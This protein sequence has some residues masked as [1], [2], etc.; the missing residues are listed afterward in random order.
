MLRTPIFITNFKTYE[1]AIG[2]NALKLAKIHQQVAED[3]GASIGI[4]VAACDL[5]RVSQAVSIPV[6][7]QHTDPVDYGSFT[8]HVLPQNIKKSGAVGTLLNHSERRLE[9]DVII[10]TLAC[11]QKA[12]LIRVLCAESPEELELLAQY[13]P[14]FLAFE[15]PELIGNSKKSVASEKP[16]SITHCVNISS[17][18]PV[19]VGAGISCADDIEVSLSLGA[20]GFL[21]ASAIVKSNDP[22]KALRKLVAAF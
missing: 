13:D 1:Q 8:G 9:K 16:T 11:S 21:V 12:S 5:Y 20:K 7:A 4:A 22:E 6:F 15:P 19:L 14:D 3:T 17:G 2:D 18:I 10:N